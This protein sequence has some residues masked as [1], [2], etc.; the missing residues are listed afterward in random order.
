MGTINQVQKK[1][2][3]SQWDII[4]FQIL[5]YCYFNDISVC[6]SDL[7]CLT[8][9]AI[10]GESELTD[11]CNAACDPNNRDKDPSVP[12]TRKI[13]TSPQSVRNCVNKAFGKRL[14]EKV[15]K[16]KKRIIVSPEMKIQTTGNILFEMKF[17]RKDDTQKS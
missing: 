6:D 13:F 5:V 2:I 10:N 16:G 9:L 11:F 3:M 15:G 14:L 7:E 17:L 8:L 4:K 12:V 1:G